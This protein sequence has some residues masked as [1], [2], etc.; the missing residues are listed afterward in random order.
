MNLPSNQR[1]NPSEE[2]MSIPLKTGSCAGYFSRGRDPIARVR[3]GDRVRLR[4]PE[5]NW[6]VH[7]QPRPLCESNLVMWEARQRE[8]SGH[9]MIGPIEVVGAEPG[10][11]LEVEIEDVV[12]GSWGWSGAEQNDRSWGRK[13]GL[14]EGSFLSLLWEIDV[15]AGLARNQFGDEVRLRPFPGLIGMPP[16]LPGRHSTVPPRNFGG[17]LDCRELVAGS[18]LFLSL[19]HIS[20]PT[21]PQRREFGGLWLRK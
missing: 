11:V 20:E 13:L 14:D 16:N 9:C 17:N 1:D 7:N 15:D 2:R 4:T 19:I 10:M 6:F 5:A 12:P 21:R 18:R 3:S 8:D